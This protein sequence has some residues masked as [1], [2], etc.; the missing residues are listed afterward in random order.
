MDFHILGPLEATD[1]NA[2]LA[3]GGSRQRALLGV[4]LL[5]ANEAVSSDRLI[6]ELWPGERSD[7]AIK[8]L[9]VAVSRLRKI[10]EPGTPAGESRVLLTR[11]PGYELR[12][13]P[14]R[15]DAKRFEAL[16]GEGRRAL[17][18]H[19]PRA[20]R[21]KLDTA[22]ELWRG[23]PLGDLAY[24]SFAQAEIARLE[25]LH[26][27]AREHRI[28]ADLALGDHE[29]VIGRLEGLIAAQPLRERPRGQLM[30]ALYRSG[31]QAEALE[32]YSDARRVLVEELGIE[33]G[34]RLR[35]LHQ[36]ILEQ[37]PALDAAPSAGEPAA[38]AP[39]SDFVGRERELAELA[40][41][42]DDVFAGRGRLFL[43]GGEPGVGKS[44][45]AEELGTRAHARGAELLVG[46]CWEA[47]GAPTYWPWTHA[48]R[49]HV[50]DTGD[51]ELEADLG[52][53]GPELAQ[54][55]PELRR[56]FPDLPA[57]SPLEPEGA[58]VRLFD[59][60]AE[61]LRASS[62]RVPIVL[63][64]DDLHA[65][66][67]GSLLMLRFLSRE[68]ASMR[69]L[70]LA[71]YRDVDPIPAGP[72]ADMLAE[73]FREHGTSRLSLAGLAEPEVAS[74]VV[75]TAPEVASPELAARLHAETDGNPLFVGEIVRLLAVEGAPPD[76]QV[77]ALA[78][79]QT[80]RDVIARRL[81]HLSEEA[82]DL[83]VLASVLGRDFSLGTLVAMSG[84]PESELLDGLDEAIAA[85]V[86]SDLPGSP[87]RLRF[88]HGLI[89]ETLY[90]G[91]T[92]G[93]R[94]RLHR[95]AI[96]GLEQ[97]HADW[98]G[99][100]LA[101]LAHHAVAGREPAKGLRYAREAADLALDQL[102]YEEAARLY[103]LALE[104][105][106]QRSGPDPHERC[107]LLL[108]AGEALARGGSTADAKRTFLEAVALATSAHLPEHRARA[109]LGYGGSRSGWQRAGDDER[110]VP[111]LEE[112]L[113]TIG[114]SDSPLRARLLARLAGAL[115][116]QPTL[117]PRGTLSR[118]AV[119]L[120]RRVGD[121]D[122]LVYALASRFM[123]V[124]G[125][126]PGELTAITDEVSELARQS[127]DPDRAF[128]ALTLRGVLAWTMLAW[129]DAGRLDA[130]YEDLAT[131]LKQPVRQWQGAMVNTVA[132]LFRG[133]FAAAE[134]LATE[135]LEFAES[136]SADADCSYRLA[137]F[138]LRREQGRLAE[139]E[140]L[141]RDAAD[142]Y[143][144]Y[145]SFRCFIPLLDWELGREED[146]RRHFDELATDEFAAL[147][148]DSEWLFCLSILAEVA[149]YLDDRERAAVLY[150]LLEP[151][152]HLNAMASGEVAIGAV[153]RPLGILATTIGDT[154]AAERHFEQALEL[155]AAAQ[156]R[157][158]HAHTQSA[159][160]HMLLARARPADAERSRELTAA[161]ASTYRELGIESV[162][163]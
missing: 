43:L 49:G 41:G 59:A 87:G 82:G 143:P 160:A 99:P 9:Q 50:R 33:P 11:S 18:A 19:D 136:L 32:V 153:A 71:I 12:V 126:D 140:E 63:V 111:L 117:E 68:L 6:D 40:G 77:D 107:E 34:R 114:E 159:Y 44:R 16:V 57:P 60:T 30:L 48:L 116:D 101:E 42:L 105:H 102:A 85:G 162:V 157:P 39:G 134:R 127:N 146:A 66:D 133:D 98:P 29:E 130:A 55:V 67:A 70:V 78:I 92:S 163:T 31:R 93:R 121:T 79:P 26:L 36:R 137:M 65:A 69:V 141:I 112:A 86:V 24:E 120:A 138:V 161:A 151:Y 46:R 61:F 113:A 129:D 158:W 4:L 83:L 125:P 154:D 97:L 27:T 156:A 110:L 100:H 37:D 62:E 88:E 20:A 45:L 7:Q 128:E 75:L 122:T 81:A 53:G 13:D 94:I 135:T 23:P 132:A 104:A 84:V 73:V 28:E 115:R 109:A 21:A 72:L 25:E 76:P 108:A 91:L 38:S 89:R 144:G 119:E 118:E 51:D 3:L 139:V 148:R 14:E 90:D 145:R 95:L 2:P 131:R 80:V 58:R 8:A 17:A 5:H 106:D 47:G 103:G 74:Y 22:L 155:N 124:W 54:I 96:A 150:R 123:A 52:R 35:E 15:L 64:L 149:A 56:R 10:L 152:G 1:G 142:R 147:P